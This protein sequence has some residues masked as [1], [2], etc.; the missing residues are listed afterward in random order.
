MRRRERSLW[1]LGGGPGSASYEVF[2]TARRRLNRRLA[3]YLHRRMAGRWTALPRSLEAGSG[4]GYCSSV[5]VDLKPDVHATLLD[6]DR[7]P[8]SLAHE[9][10]ARLGRVEGD[11]YTLPFPDQ[12]FD[13]VFN[14]S[15]MEH[16][17]SFALALAEMIRVTRDGGT[18]FVGV[19]YKYGPFAP[20]TWLP[21]THGVSVWMGTLFTQA[22]LRAACRAPGVVVE[23]SVRY[24]FG[25]FIGLFMVKE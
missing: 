10:D 17:G 2:D 7:E 8:L 5:L 13:L 16:L 24:F 18:I 1:S 4:P 19:P 11:L 9:R 25:C 14:S 21:V 23:D 3:A 22:D 12:S 20:F 15:T 6:L